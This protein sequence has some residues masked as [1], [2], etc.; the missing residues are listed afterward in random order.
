M[1]KRLKKIITI[2]FLS[3]LLFNCSDDE[4]H[5]YDFSGVPNYFYKFTVTGQSNQD[6]LNPQNVDGYNFDEMKLYYVKNGH[7]IEVYENNLT[8]PRNINLSSFW[9]IEEG[10]ENREVFYLTATLFG[11]KGEAGIQTTI[12]EWNDKKKDSINLD[13]KLDDS[14]S[15]YLSKIYVNN[16]LYWEMESGHLVDKLIQIVHD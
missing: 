8:F 11:V 1:K 6:M 9:F 13:Y 15:N 3:M 5:S 7:P 16:E 14:N 4:S 2:L 10:K 12:I